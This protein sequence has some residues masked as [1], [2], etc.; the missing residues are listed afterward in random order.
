M[1]T[2]KA[3]QL[4]IVGAGIGGLTAAIY[5]A[6]HGLDVLVVEKNASVGG[7]MGEVHQAG[8]RW[9]TGPSVITMLPV[10]ERI[11]S[12]A[13]RDLADYL[14]MLPV[15]PLTRYYY[16]DG[17]VIN[18]SAD[19]S[20]MLPQVAS[21]NNR[22]VEGYLSYLG[23]V[24]RLH[25]ITGPVFIYDQPP[26]PASFLKVSPTDYLKIDPFRTMQQAIDSFVE[27]PQLRQML[28]RYATYVGA[29]PFEAPATLNVIAHVEL[30]QGVFYPSGGVYRIAEALERL[31][32]ELGVRIQKNTPV[33][34]ILVDG[35]T[36]VGVES[37]AG[38]TIHAD[39]VLMNV[40]IGTVYEN[41]LPDQTRRSR[42]TTRLLHSDL[43]CSGFIML[44]GVEGEHPELAHH[45]IFF[46]SDY[47]R[48]F[49]QIFTAKSPPD[50][51]TIYVAVTSKTDPGHAPRA[52][53]NWFVL[54]NSPAVDAR[55]DWDS[56]KYHYRQ[57]VL[58]RLAGFGL[59]I[60]GCIAVERLITPKDLE[61]RSGA[62]RGALYGLS[63]NNL[64]AAFRR[65]TPRD[66]HFQNLYYCGGTTHP[67]GGVPLVM[68]S[69]RNAA[70]MVAEDH[71]R[72][73]AVSTNAPRSGE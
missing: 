37:Q 20:V 73:R 50:E 13:G 41:L 54:V 27:A 24:A 68:I 55:I 26:K 64:F 69:G 8:Y 70:H 67:G 46:S 35:R 47:R 22:D 61:I 11:F 66:P 9:D 25:R 18:A 53:E 44:L 23:Y 10:I 1:N 7:K 45:N 28:G 15:D 42:R 71:R 3:A 2:G 72:N 49:D 39:Q 62:R 56:F 36:A 6:L 34:R 19:L 59:N 29:N 17:T 43:S 31:S 48:E 14:T 16:P 32:H 38:E 63:S 5:G 30:S 40:D 33:N 4:L 52:C 60:N 21:L 51:P 58:D 57:L 65:P 12:D